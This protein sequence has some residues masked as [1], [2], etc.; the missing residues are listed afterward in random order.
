[1]KE[2]TNVTA[3]NIVKGLL[4]QDGGSRSTVSVPTVAMQ[5]WYGM[6]FGTQQK[7]DARSLH[8]SVVF[9]KLRCRVAP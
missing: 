1:M 7:G 2:C 3:A 5:N 8:I 6:P 4:I 9:T